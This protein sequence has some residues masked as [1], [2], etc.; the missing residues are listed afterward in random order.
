MIWEHRSSNVC[1]SDTS[2]T[3]SGRV[4]KLGNK[5]ASG[6]SA[7]AQVQVFTPLAHAVDELRKSLVGPTKN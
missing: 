5:V 7:K 2:R 1:I 4:Y 6:L 3:V